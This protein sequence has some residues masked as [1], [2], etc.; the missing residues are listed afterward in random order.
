MPE[1]AGSRLKTAMRNA[2]FLLLSILLFQPPLRQPDDIWLHPLFMSPRATES[3]LAGNNEDNAATFNPDTR[4]WFLPPAIDR[5][6]I[7]FLGY[8]DGI[9]AGRH[10][11]PRT[12]WFNGAALS[13]GAQCLLGDRNGKTA[14]LEFTPDKGTA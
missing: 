13:N 6:G 9:P 4:I 14:V 10:E 5:Y 1:I 7:A 3:V 12:P 8:A 11:R 2:I